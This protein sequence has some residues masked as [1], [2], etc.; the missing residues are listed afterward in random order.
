MAKVGRPLNSE[1]A[2]GAL[3]GLIFSESN[4]VNYVRR[5][6][7][8][9]YEVTTKRQAQAAALAEISERWTSLSSSDKALWTEFAEDHFKHD[10]FG[11]S[12]KAPAFSW[13]VGCSQNLRAVKNINNPTLILDGRTPTIPQPPEFERYALTRSG[14]AK[15]TTLY[16]YPNNDGNTLIRLYFGN[17]QSLGQTLNFSECVYEKPI[18][19]TNTSWSQNTNSTNPYLFLGDWTIYAQAVDFLTGLASDFSKFNVSIIE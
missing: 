3:G 17:R 15:R 8:P 12:F 16:F 5:N 1:K 2:R 9:K 13:F 14:R 19:L 10:E 7:K 18:G 11:R 4:N 6:T